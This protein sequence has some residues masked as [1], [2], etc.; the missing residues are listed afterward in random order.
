MRNSV[1]LALAVAAVLA[2]AVGTSLFSQD[3]PAASRPVT[4]VT[5]GGFDDNWTGW[6]ATNQGTLD[7]EVV[8]DG[9]ASLRIDSTS[10]VDGRGPVQYLDLKPGTRY[11]VSFATKLKDVVPNKKDRYYPYGSCGAYVQFWGGMGVNVFLPG[12]CLTGTQRWEPYACTVTTAKEKTEHKYYIKPSIR[13]ATG[14]V[15]FDCIGVRELP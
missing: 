9:P 1:L 8:Y 15:W 12:R 2:T 4:I 14:T 13:Q 10:F 6:T 5:N 3:M 7:E 11:V